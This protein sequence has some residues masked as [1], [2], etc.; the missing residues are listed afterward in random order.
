[1][2]SN[3]RHA[4]NIVFFLLGDSQASEFSVPTFRN[5]LFLL[6]RLLFWR[7]MKMERGVPKRRHR[8]FRRL[9]I[10]QKKSYRKSCVGMRCLCTIFLICEIRDV[11]YQVVSIIF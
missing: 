9:G 7:P 5:P 1:L 6:H 8:N 11:F 3:I 4:V 10:T 2:I